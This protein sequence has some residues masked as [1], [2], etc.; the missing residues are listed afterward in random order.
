MLRFNR[1]IAIILMLALVGCNSAQQAP[2]DVSNSPTTA[3]TSP[4]DT[5]TSDRDKTAPGKPEG[6][7]ST[8]DSQTTGFD[9]LTTVISNTRS[10]V[11]TGDFTKAA[12]EFD[13]FEDSW[14]Q[15]EDGVKA[16]SQDTYAAIEDGM[17]AV[18]AAVK[19]KNKTQALTA[20]QALD[21]NIATAAKP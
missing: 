6:G 1:A 7:K 5:A 15:V 16:K 3:T 4:T 18:N 8:T 11:E 12:T 14:S 2:P 10:A 19:G 21:K 20:L 9:A 13:Q 17:D